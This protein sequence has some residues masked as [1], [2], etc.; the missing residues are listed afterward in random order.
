VPAADDTGRTGQFC[1]FETTDH[2]TGSTLP[3]LFVPP[4]APQVMDGPALEE[5][6]FVRDQMANMAW[7]VERTIT[8]PSGVVRDRRDEAPP[9]AFTPGPEAAADMDY[10]L[11]NE[12]P[13]RWIPLLPVSNGYGTFV[14]RKGAIVRDGHPVLA[15]GVV[16]DGDRALLLQDEE[17]PREGLRLRRIPS[18]ARR[19]DGTRVLWTAR[20]TDVGRGGGSSGLAFD[21]AVRRAAPD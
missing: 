14:L 5:V 1:L 17:V 12:P 10:R 21:S 11:A 2:D 3:G 13:D 16:L 4:S 15:R 7:A 6:M 8:G 9:P 20:R 18:V 19:A